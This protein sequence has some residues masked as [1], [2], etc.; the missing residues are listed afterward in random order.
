[1]KRRVGGSKILG[2]KMVEKSW[3]Y[4]MKRGFRVL[5]TPIRL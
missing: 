1:M 5:S 3:K 4:F 2:S